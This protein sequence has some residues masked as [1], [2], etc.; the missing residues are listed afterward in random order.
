MKVAHLSEVDSFLLQW[1]KSSVGEFDHVYL[2]VFKEDSSKLPKDFSFQNLTIRFLEVNRPWGYIINCLQLRFYL[3][4]DNPD[5]LHV[6]Y[7]SGMGLLGRLSSNVKRTYL[8]VL[9]SDVL[10]TPGKSRLMKNLVMKNLLS[11]SSLFYTSEFLG[12]R[13]TDFC[14]DTPRKHLPLGVDSKKFYSMC[15][16]KQ[17][18]EIVFGI[19]KRVDYIYGVDLAIKSFKM[20]YDY[21]E[22]L[23]ADSQRKFKMKIYGN[24]FRNDFVEMVN[25]FNLQE[26]ISFEGFVAPEKVPEVINSFSI[27]LNPS[28]SESFGMFILESSSC[29]VPVIASSIG[30][31]PEVLR[32]GVNGL[33]FKSEDVLDLFEK[34]RLLAF[35]DDLRLALGIEARK[36][37]LENYMWENVTFGPYVDFVRSI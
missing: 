25:K 7:A 15:T 35:N 4:N 9:G 16:S 29:G 8:S 21:N 11:Y 1:I 24:I 19:V 5:F 33:L 31:I 10:L 37:V 13:I 12:R 2:Y 18:I 28:R 32:D 26:K 22:S 36:F 30:G 6:H 27:S 20:L 34:M 23:P 17:N 3:K 14:P